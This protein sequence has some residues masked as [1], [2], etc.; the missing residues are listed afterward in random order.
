M[1]AFEFEFASDSDVRLC[2]P[3]T[4]KDIGTSCLNVDGLDRAVKETQTCGG[5]GEDEV[6]LVLME[7]LS[8][9][10]SIED[11]LRKSM[12]KVLVTPLSPQDLKSED[13]NVRIS[14]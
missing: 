6:G 11:Q 8:F 14:F 1:P 12:S 4:L 9:P 2:F 13:S 3:A 7:M 5:K 10:L